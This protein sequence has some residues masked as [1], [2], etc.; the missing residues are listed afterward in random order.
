MNEINLFDERW[1]TIPGFENYEVSNYGMVKSLNYCN[2]KQQKL[3]KQFLDRYGYYA[4]SL[5]GKC[6]KVHQLVAMAFLNHKPDGTLNKVVN[7]IDSDRTNNKLNNLEVVTPRENI[8][9]S[10]KKRLRKSKHI[11]L[12]HNN[13]KWVSTVS[14]NGKRYNL[15]SY[16]SEQEAGEMYLKSLFH[17]NN[18]TFED[19]F[20]SLIDN[21][22]IFTS[23]TFTSKY[24]GVNLHPK[25][26]KWI[27]SITRNKHTYR[28]GQFDNEIDAHIEF[29][30]ALDAI[31]N[32][33]FDEYYVNKKKYTSKTSECNG[34]YLNRKNN[35][36]ISNITYNKKS[37]Y[38]G[39]F[40]TENEASNE[41]NKALK[42]ISENNFDDY[43]KNFK[44]R[45]R[46]SCEYDGIYYNTKKLK[47]VL[48]IDEKICGYYDTKDKANKSKEK[49]LN[50]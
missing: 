28:L 43:L 8:I 46:I 6:K 41:Y 23:E 45:Y 50:K 48:Y 16:T 20:Q 30:K 15:G 7:H 29:E 37:I 2:T 32:N 44:N 3:L 39:S 49:R 17:I 27:A 1:K 10:C 24:R 11:G 38:I 22:K 34:V 21:R 13:K 26:N 19:F 18:N 4:V 40:K 14:I 35:K 31:T 12:R 9:H 25:T 42:L 47:W 5:N 36:W 33:Y